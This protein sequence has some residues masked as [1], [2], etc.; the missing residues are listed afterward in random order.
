MLLIILYGYNVPYHDHPYAW[1]GMDMDRNLKFGDGCC[2]TGRNFLVASYSNLQ[3]STG[4]SA[5]V[6][7]R[8]H[9]RHAAPPRRGDARVM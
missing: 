5:M 7:Y 3:S 1:I 4:Q 6:A 9:R 8:G 2:S